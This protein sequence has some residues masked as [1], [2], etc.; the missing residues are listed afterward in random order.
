MPC[1]TVLVVNKRGLLL[2]HWSSGQISKNQ[3]IPKS[4]LFY[5]ITHSSGCKTVEK[6]FFSF[7]L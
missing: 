3:N 7:I 5:A 4:Q 2:Q 1:E 6:K